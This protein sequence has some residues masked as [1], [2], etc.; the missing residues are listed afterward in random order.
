MCYTHTLTSYF[1]LF[2]FITYFFVAFVFN[3]PTALSAFSNEIMQLSKPA[4]E[5]N[6]KVLLYNA[7]VMNLQPLSLS[8]LSPAVPTAAHFAD[9]RVSL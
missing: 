1:F 5:K 6:L 7:D 8:S 3:N 2:F 4:G 9:R